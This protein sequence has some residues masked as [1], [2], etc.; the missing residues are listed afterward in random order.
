MNSIYRCP[1]FV[2]IFLI[3]FNIDTTIL[4]VVQREVKPTNPIMRILM[5]SIKLPFSEKIKMKR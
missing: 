5:E 2:E 3:I 4:I 1:D